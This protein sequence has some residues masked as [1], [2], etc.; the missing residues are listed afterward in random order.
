MGLPMAELQPDDGPEEMSPKGVGRMDMG[1][2]VTHRAP[3]RGDD[4]L[5]LGGRWASGTKASST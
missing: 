5:S 1:P 3:R 2:R 4:V